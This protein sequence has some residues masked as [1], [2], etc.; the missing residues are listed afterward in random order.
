MISIVEGWMVSPRKSR[1][2]SPCFS[3]TSTSTPRLASSSPSIAPAGPPP[4][5]TLVAGRTSCVCPE[6][7]RARGSCLTCESSIRPPSFV[8]D[9]RCLHYGR[10]QPGRAIELGMTDR[11]LGDG[12]RGIQDPLLAG[13][14][15]APALQ[16]F[17]EVAALDLDGAT[18]L[19]AR[20]LPAAQAPVD[21]TLAHS[22]LLAELRY[23]EQAQA[24][25]LLRTLLRSEE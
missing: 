15:V 18:Q 12:R 6:G 20:D 21:P 2:K 5:I 25:P 24:L 11:F 10:S 16:V 22:Q 1:R 3:S 17:F 8:R 7:S 4:A 19:H 23:R 9:L 13:R 14:S